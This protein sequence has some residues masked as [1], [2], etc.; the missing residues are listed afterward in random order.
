[1]NPGLARA[2]LAQIDSEALA[3][4]TLEFVKV[5]SCD[6]NLYFNEANLP[7]ICYSPAHETAHSDDERVS[8]TRLAH[9]AGVYALAA[10]DCCRVSG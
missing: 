8:A 2:V 6:A 4:D 5:R 10:A 9:C 3:R 1:M 7:V